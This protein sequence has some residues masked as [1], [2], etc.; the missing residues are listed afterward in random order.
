M[1]YSFD[2]CSDDDASNPLCIHSEKTIQSNGI[3]VCR[4]CYEVVEDIE[5]TKDWKSYNSNG[6]D[7]NRCHIKSKEDSK[8]IKL[9][10]PSYPLSIIDAAN[11]YFDDVS[12]SLAL[13]NNKTTI[14]KGKKRLAWKC[15]CIYYSYKDQGKVV[16]WKEV[17]KKENVR[18]NVVINKDKEFLELF[19]EKKFENRAINL[20]H[21]I[22]SK[23][24]I[25]TD[26]NIEE[27]I[28][29]V[30]ALYSKL[31]K[32]TLSKA[33]P[34]SIASSIIYLY[35][36]GRPEFKGRFTKSKY[37]EVVNLCNST[38]NKVNNIIESKLTFDN[39]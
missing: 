4:E 39:K 30:D 24:G 6:G 23:L 21:N 38:L 2:E 1:F 31:D 36:T 26:N 25:C 35:L 37:L 11:S 20:T 13:K 15:V 28:Q 33:K 12:K 27:H 7:P 10:D 14:F 22:L 32:A 29:N 19:P 8:I 3:T 34:T 17:A 9:D 18:L 16:S 5:Y